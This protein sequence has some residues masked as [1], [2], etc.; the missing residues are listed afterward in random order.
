MLQKGWLEIRNI[1]L[2]LL[3]FSWA[4]Q[5]CCSK[6]TSRRLWSNRE[7][8][9]MTSVTFW[10][11]R[12]FVFCR[13]KCT[14]WSSC[15]KFRGTR[16]VSAGSRS[17]LHFYLCCLHFPELFLSASKEKCLSC[18][19]H[20]QVRRVGGQ[21]EQWRLSYNPFCLLTGATLNSAL[22]SAL[23]GREKKNKHQPLFLF[24]SGFF[25]HKSFELYFRR[26]AL[27]KR[28][29]LLKDQCSQI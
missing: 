8:P 14:R 24:H 5:R 7:A 10:A 6:A 22:F 2:C 29:I 16:R 21:R 9:S 28:F 17:L 25:P 23:V 19:C 20:L 3:G 4:R 27:W 15:F 11:W 12:R 18:G 26:A 13:N 1:S